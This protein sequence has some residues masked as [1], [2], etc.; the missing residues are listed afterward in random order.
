MDID[1]RDES[2]NYEHIAI[3]HKSIKFKLTAF[4]YNKMIHWNSELKMMVKIILFKC[5]RCL[6]LS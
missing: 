3:L 6:F 2:T 1:E 4:M 5:E